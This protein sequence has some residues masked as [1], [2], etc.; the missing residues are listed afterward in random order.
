MSIAFCIGNGESR[1]GYNV[2]S[3][4]AR[5]KIFAANAYHR[6][7]NPDI[8]ICC[9]KRMVQEALHNKNYTGPIYTR[10]DW[11]AT[12]ASP[13]VLGLPDFAWSEDA[14]W[15]QSFHWGSGLHAVHL[16]CK[17]KNQILV[18][19]GHDFYGLD[20]KHNNIYK[21]T[22]NYQSA[23]Y[24]AVDPSFWIR[25]FLLLFETYSDVQF[26]ICQPNVDTWQIPE[27]WINQETKEIASCIQIRNNVFIQELGDLKDELGIN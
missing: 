10:K 12:F 9:D 16:A 20:G 3:L 11:I 13:R 27:S 26:Y 19:I 17:Q 2:Q 21:G 4:S 25:Q 1:I 24:T 8:L 23:D 22:N 7:H 18:V 14:K 6:D 15:K 5:G